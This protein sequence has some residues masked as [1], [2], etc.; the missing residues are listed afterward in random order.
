MPRRCP[1]R[2]AVALGALLAGCVALGAAAQTTTPTPTLPSLLRPDVHGDRRDPPRFRRPGAPAPAVPG[3]IP[4]APG[5]RTPPVAVPQST[6]PKS[7]PRDPRRPGEL[8]KFEVPKFGN[9]AGGRRRRRRLFLFRPTSPRRS[10]RPRREPSPGPRPSP[11]TNSVSGQYRP[12]LRIPRGLPPCSAHPQQ[13]AE[14]RG[15]HISRA[16]APPPIYSPDILLALRRVEP[17]PFE[18]ESAS[19]S[20]PSSS[21]RRSS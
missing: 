17:D 8:P 15:A 9:S 18:A 10:G 21:G 13:P 19:A 20:A 14:R 12:S 5:A 6:V 16:R 7:A 2:I 3:A 4:T 1:S 11:H